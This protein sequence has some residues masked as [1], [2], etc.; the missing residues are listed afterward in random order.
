M[1]SNLADRKS[2][3]NSESGI[4]RL[5]V[6]LLNSGMDIDEVRR[7]NIPPG[8]FEFS[9]DTWLDPDPTMRSFALTVVEVKRWRD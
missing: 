6:W 4:Y 5:S 3:V 1:D 9:L 7:A 8:D 2:V